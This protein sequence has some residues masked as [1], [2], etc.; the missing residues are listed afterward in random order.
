[1]LLL[2]FGT[3][4]SAQKLNKEEKK[5]TINGSELWQKVINYH[6]PKVIWEKFNGKVHL[7]S[8]HANGNFSD[9]ELEVQKEKDF[10]QCKRFVKDVIAIKGIKNGKCFH[11]V[12]GENKPTDD[13]VKKYN[14]SCEDTKMTKEHH[15]CH[16]IWHWVQSL[17]LIRE[18][19]LEFCSTFRTKYSSLSIFVPVFWA[20]HL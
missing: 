19:L 4:I 7:I 2:T 6:D 12:N 14:L 9:E 5:P 10:Y 16:R 15:T 17:C 18:N 3:N 20:L 8:V 13:D 1:M 11:S